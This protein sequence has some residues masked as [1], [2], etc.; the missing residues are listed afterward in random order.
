MRMLTLYPLFANMLQ[1]NFLRHEPSSPL[2][3][4]EF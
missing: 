1:L 3:R 2:I 4:F